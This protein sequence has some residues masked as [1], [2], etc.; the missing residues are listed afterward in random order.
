VC[1]WN[2]IDGTPIRKQSAQTND[3][4]NFRASAQTEKRHMN[5]EA[6]QR[7][8]EE[9]FALR[10]ELGASLSVWKGGREV[11]RLAGGHQDR[12]RTQ[13]WTAD[14]P[15]LVWSATKGPA[16]ACV[17]HALMDAGV[18]LRTRV[19]HLWPEFGAAGKE[20]VTLRMLL[21]HQAGL[22][23]LDK[24]PPVEDRDA[25]FAALAAQRPA[26][27]PG[28][29]HGYHPRT[30]G[31]LLEAVLLRLTG[32]ERL[33]DYWRRV[34]AVPLDLEFW[35]GVP[36]EVLPRVAPVFSSKGL[37]P[38]DDPFFAAFMTP[39]SLT[40]RS[41][42]SPKGLHS[43]PAMNTTEARMAQYPGFGGIGTA[44]ALAK[45]YAM[46]ACGG[47]WEGRS[48]FPEEVD[49]HL[50]EGVQGA[51]L[52]LQME[53]SFSCGFMRDPV[54]AFGAKTRQTFGPHTAAFGHPGAGGS[55]AFADPVNGMGFAYVMNQMEPGVL[56]N[57]RA[58]ALVE[59]CYT[60]D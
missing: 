40:S 37:M 21:Q 9:N 49:R 55:V 20:D 32:S 10:G 6:V 53:T 8:F 27:A 56:P 31:F 45:F 44:S 35:I 57:S 24:A 2:G 23:A 42:A 1:C 22:C 7:V 60:G 13:A 15:V 52:V 30:F 18:S 3:A 39:G 50:S 54:D 5:S 17:L 25:V 36:S 28:T 34:F 12:E 51:D 26:W 29:A 43:A 46:L 33:G 11:A 58:M 38:K 4:G 19:S 14:T 16:A 47:H 59:A 41:F 48:V